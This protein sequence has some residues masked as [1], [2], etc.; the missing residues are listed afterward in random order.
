MRLWEETARRML[1]ALSV[2]ESTLS[3]STR[4]LGAVEASGPRAGLFTFHEE[5]RPENVQALLTMALKA[6]SAAS[7]A[8]SIAYL[9]CVFARRDAAL[10]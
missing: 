8:A 9:Y 7:E 2:L 3:A 4:Q 10:D 6:L 5:I 1:M